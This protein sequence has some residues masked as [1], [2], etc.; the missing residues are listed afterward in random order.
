MQGV[1]RF[2]AASTGA[3]LLAFAVTLV[4]CSGA[5]GEAGGATFTPQPT[6]TSVPTSCAQIGEFA[7]AGAASAGAGFADVT[8]PSGS[9][10]A[11]PTL[12][13]GGVGLYAIAEFDVCTPNADPLTI[14]SYFTTQLGANGWTTSARYPFDGGY[15][16]VC[17][18]PYCW[19]KDTA[20]RY[21]SLEQVTARGNG[22]VTYHLRL[23]TPP[24]APNCP[25][26]AFQ[27]PPYQGFFPTANTP[28][29]P[30]P[31]LT[32][33]GA[34]TKTGNLT[35]ESLCS[36]GTATTI[37]SYLQ[38]E[39]AMLG[40][41]QGSLPAADQ[42]GKTNTTFTG[43]VKGSRGVS[44]QTTNGKQLTPNGYVWTINYCAA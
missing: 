33:F 9:L 18:D 24:P 26:P 40:W 25:T 29:L 3:L 39:L 16:A 6:A 8:F 12:H 11:R 30:L 31:P 35:G 42:C 27:G 44:W 32:E 37:N 5:N 10:S 4:A 34:L 38:S 21:V 2:S 15:L 41:T 7:G 1:A 28:D 36:A 17:G 14:E 13:P 20:P 19:F 22:V 23:A 43:W